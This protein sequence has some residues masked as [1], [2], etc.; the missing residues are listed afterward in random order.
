MST[1]TTAPQLV[2]P[3]RAATATQAPR[4]RGKRAYLILA[5]VVAAVLVAIGGYKLLTAGQE[6]TD[7]AQVEADVV[8]LSIRVAGPVLR[9]AVPDNAVVHKGDLLLE[10]DPRE[11]AAQMKQAEAELE[12]ATA[13][14]AA[15]DAQVAVT[16]AGAK[17]GFSTARAQVSTSS[18]AAGNAE[19]Q[20]A[21]ARAALSRSE[22]Q[23]RKAELDLQR[24][25]TL[26]EQSVLPQQ[27][28]DDAQAGYDTAQAAV[29][30]A[31]AQLTAAEESRRMA[32][33]KV[34]EAQGQLDQSA[35]IDSKIAA[36]RASAA[37]AH[38]RVK[39]AEAALDQAKLR[40]DYTHVVA[41]ADGQV[42]RLSVREGQF[43]GAGQLVAEL[44]PSETYVVANFKETQVGNMKPGQ[45]VE[46]EVDA[47]S[48]KTL[49]GRV[50]SLS[51][52]TGARFSLLPPDNA[53]GNFVKVV[54]RVPVRIAW[55]HP[56]EGL[57]LRAGLSAHVTV[58]TH[59]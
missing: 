26:H 6:D 5:G 46:V 44:V 57:A 10:L 32:Q 48:G 28:L 41:P 55:S 51:G 45:V 59:N 56:P 8:P 19:A 12:S 31:R 18:A 2:T 33:G 30:G 13:Q 36:A 39:A 23:A 34:A 1:P 52:G 58:H 27:A 11:Y 14:A 17:G 22:A 38:A 20:V 3:E 54:Q 24:A 47:F 15:A 4:K 7:D 43:L 9:V 16:E 50:E 40:L 25:K 29:E 35:P 42:S 53:S 21:A 37:L 49:E